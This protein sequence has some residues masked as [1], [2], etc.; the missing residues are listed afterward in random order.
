M[1][2]A[3]ISWGKAGEVRIVGQE[4]GEEPKCQSSA[5]H[6]GV[7]GGCPDGAA[8]AVVET[9]E[10]SELGV[11]DA[12]P[13]FDALGRITATQERHCGQELRVWLD[14]RG[15][16]RQEEVGVGF[17]MGGGQDRED[18]ERQC[19]FLLRGGTVIDEGTQEFDPLEAFARAHREAGAGGLGLEEEG[20]KRTFLPDG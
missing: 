20:E 7:Q 1:L 17:H 14:S 6:R 19:A 10:S 16:V 11:G 13:K 2:S 15:P 9:D 18:V 12:V 5:A 4:V 3:A 8:R